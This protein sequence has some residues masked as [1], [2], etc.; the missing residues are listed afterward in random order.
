MFDFIKCPSCKK[1]LQWSLADAKGKRLEATLDELDSLKRGIITCV[2]CSTNYPVLDGIPWIFTDAENQITQWQNRI[3]YYCESLFYQ[4]NQISEKLKQK[5]QILDLTRQR[6]EITEKGLSDQ[7]AY[8]LK[9]LEELSENKALP[10]GIYRGLG[11]KLPMVQSLSSYYPNLHRDWSYGDE[12]VG[13]MSENHQSVQALRSALGDFKPEAVV[14]LGAGGC[15]LAYDFHRGCGVKQTLVADINPMLLYAAKKLI[16]GEQVDLVDFPKAPKSL[17]VNAVHRSLTAEKS[18]S[19]E[20]FQFVFIDGVKTYLSAKKVCAVVTPWFIDVAPRKLA[21]L[22]AVLN[23]SLAKG[24]VW[25]QFGSLVYTDADSE[26]QLSIEE[27]RQIAKDSGFEIQNLE[28]HEI[29]YM[30]DP[31]SCHSRR[32]HVFCWK[33]VKV[34]DVEKPAEYKYL[35]EWLSD[36]STAIPKTQHFSVTGMQHGLFADL[37]GQVNGKATINQ[38]SEKFAKKFQIPIEQARGSV[39]QFFVKVYEEGKLGVGQ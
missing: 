5:K 27:V 1:D 23:N 25:L 36:F 30:R 34:E 6:M 35:P 37:L 12:V 29:P 17:H 16:R 7:I 33:A 28:T 8:T 4:Q 13:G 2:H 38:L 11:T 26:N 18:L 14:F 3:R 32:E 39:H 19:A 9:L 15:R 20:A 24:G 22:L 31:N 10:L 21:D